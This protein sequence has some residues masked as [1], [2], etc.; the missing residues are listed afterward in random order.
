MC[1]RIDAKKSRSLLIREAAAIRVPKT[2]AVNIH[3]AY[4]AVSAHCTGKRER[5]RTRDVIRFSTLA[6]SIT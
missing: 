4:I 6:I 5:F 3:H 1:R 2:T